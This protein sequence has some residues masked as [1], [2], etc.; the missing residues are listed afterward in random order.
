LQK[1]I[2]ISDGLPDQ[3]RWWGICII[4]GGAIPKLGIW[5]LGHCTW[6]MRTPHV[7]FGDKGSAKFLVELVAWER[8]FLFPNTASPSFLPVSPPILRRFT[9]SG[10]RYHRMMRWNAIRPSY[11]PTP[12]RLTFGNLAKDLYLIPSSPLRQ[13]LQWPT[14]GH[15]GPRTLSLHLKYM[16]V[17]L[18]TAMEF[19]RLDSLFTVGYMSKPTNFISTYWQAFEKGL[20]VC[21]GCTIL[22]IIFQYIVCGHMYPLS[23]KNPV[24]AS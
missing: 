8:H 22:I 20:L 15:Y 11:T 13:L 12:F 16:V 19:H 10:A 3:S 1:F 6:P 9:R 18:P 24:C 21:R 23:A 17:S 5:D 2:I 7:K 4:Q 14:R